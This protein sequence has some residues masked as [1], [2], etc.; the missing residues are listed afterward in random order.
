MLLSGLLSFDRTKRVVGVVSSVV[1]YA[2]E[3]EWY[4]PSK[5]RI[6]TGKLCS[7]DLVQFLPNLL[8][9]FD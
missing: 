6:D 2:F 9:L 3:H 5:K 4:A 8:T 7:V 1:A